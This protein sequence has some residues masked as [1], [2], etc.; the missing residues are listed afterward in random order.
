MND[1]D[2]DLIFEEYK[3]D[4]MRESF[5]RFGVPEGPFGSS[6]RPSHIPAPSET[7]WRA[8][9]GGGFDRHPLSS[10][11]NKGEDKKRRP[12]ETKSKAPYHNDA[13]GDNEGVV[14]DG[15][16]PD[17]ALYQ[18]QLN[19]NRY[20]RNYI[21]EANFQKVIDSID[22]RIKEAYN[23]GHKAALESPANRA[24]LG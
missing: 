20:L 15:I 18:I 17:A 12:K 8:N 1:K 7:E 11:I 6:F 13:T 4:I 14:T 23:L 22:S 16:D 19:A 10:Q 5:G 24:N 21:D 3:K 2:S 9:K